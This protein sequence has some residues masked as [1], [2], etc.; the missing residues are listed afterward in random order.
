MCKLVLANKSTHASNPS[1]AGFESILSS[2]V[3]I[4]GFVKLHPQVAEGI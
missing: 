4:D 3:Q 1:K 2:I